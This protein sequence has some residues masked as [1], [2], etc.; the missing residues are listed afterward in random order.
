MTV[1]GVGALEV[2]TVSVATDVLHLTLVNI[3]AG[4]GV[5]L[6]PEARLAAALHGP[7]LE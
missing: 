7:H 2:E 1:A 4:P 5:L 6:E 3:Q